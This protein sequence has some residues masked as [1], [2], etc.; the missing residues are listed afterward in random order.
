MIGINT[1]ECGTCDD[2]VED[3]MY[4]QVTGTGAVCS[5]CMKVL[6]RW[7]IQFPL[8]DRQDLIDRLKHRNKMTGKLTEPV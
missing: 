5:I 2:L 7:S 1:T 4:H 8:R 3:S 6:E